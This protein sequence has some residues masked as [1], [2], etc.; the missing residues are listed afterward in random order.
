MKTD[1]DGTNVAAF[2]TGTTASGLFTL[3]MNRL[4]GLAQH[5]YAPDLALFGCNTP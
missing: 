1:A 3:I 5:E 2:A 4:S